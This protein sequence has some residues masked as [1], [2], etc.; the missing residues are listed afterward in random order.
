MF[1][2]GGREFSYPIDASAIVNDGEVI[3]EEEL[4]AAAG[5]LGLRTSKELVAASRAGS[6]TA[7]ISV[8]FYNG[9]PIGAQLPPVELLRALELTGIG[10]WPRRLR[11]RGL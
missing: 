2:A 9:P 1:L 10:C 11:S 5:D 3:G 6:G 4:L 8:V 7:S